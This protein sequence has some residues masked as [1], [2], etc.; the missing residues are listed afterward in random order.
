MKEKY[1]IGEISKLF[2]IPIQTLHYFEKCGFISPEKDMQNNYRYY[3]AWDVNALLDSKYLH[4]FCFSNAEIRQIL[5]HDDL[6]TITDR[7]DAQE[8]NF[9]DII[10]H[11]QAILNELHEKKRMLLSLPMLTGKF[12]EITRTHLFFN[13]YRV[14]N[15]YPSAE[16]R[17]QPIQVKEWLPFQPFIKATFMIPF[18]NIQ[19]CTLEK[20]D[21]LWGFSISPERAKELQM[22]TGIPV[23]YIPAQRCIYTIFAA[24]GTH[25]FIHALQ[26]EVFSPLTANGYTIADAPIGKLLVRSH[27]G[28]QYTR[29]FEIWVPIK[30]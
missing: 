7:L 28:G 15:S 27:E 8:K 11:H 21:C 6:K 23:E 1:K 24:T 18:E 5:N 26:K 17:T 2:G 16:N 13:P 20:A 4:S 14:N 25:T 30:P 22:P 10:Y 19:A 3:T 9:L 12:K 29:Y